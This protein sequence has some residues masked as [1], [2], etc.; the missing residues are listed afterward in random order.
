MMYEYALFVEKDGEAEVIPL[1]PGGSETVA[2][3]L[4]RFYAEGDPDSIYSHLK[5][6]VMRREVG[7]WENFSV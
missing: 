4:A 2:E 5:Y 1:L 3:K 7:E 6:K